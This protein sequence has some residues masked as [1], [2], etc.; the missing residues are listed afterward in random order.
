MRRDTPLTD[1]KLNKQNWQYSEQVIRCNMRIWLKQFHHNFELNMNWKNI[2]EIHTRM[3]YKNVSILDIRI[4]A[5]QTWFTNFEMKSMTF[6][7]EMT[8]L[9]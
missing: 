8:D 7:D 1:F 9:P 2:H 3:T 6:I 5:K 4:I